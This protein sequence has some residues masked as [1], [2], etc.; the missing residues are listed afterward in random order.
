MLREVDNLKN[1]ENASILGSISLA[2]MDFLRITNHLKRAL[3]LEATGHGFS[4]IKTV[5]VTVTTR[6][7]TRHHLDGITLFPA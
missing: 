1:G 4:F 6:R 7:Q 5:G 2:V 3:L